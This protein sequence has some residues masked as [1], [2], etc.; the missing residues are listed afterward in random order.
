MGIADFYLYGGK[1]GGGGGSSLPSNWDVESN[2]LTIKGE[3]LNSLGWRCSNKDYYFEKGFSW[4][5]VD[6]EDDQ[7]FR[8]YD[9]IND[10]P[11]LIILFRFGGNVKSYCLGISTNA[12]GAQIK[13]R[14]NDNATRGSFEYLDHTWYY[15]RTNPGTDFGICDDLELIILSGVND[16]DVEAAKLAID[17]AGIS[18][19]A[20]ND[21]TQL[22]SP[23]KDYTIAA[24]GSASDFS[25]ATFKVNSSGDVYG[26]NFYSNGV[27]I[28][29][30]FTGATSSS[31]GAPGIVPAPSSADVN[32]FLK[33]DGSWAEAGTPSNWNINPTSL[34]MQD[35]GKEVNSLGWYCGNKENYYESTI[36]WHT[37]GN[38]HGSSPQGH[39]FYK[40]NTKPAL[41][42]AVHCVDDYWLHSLAVSTE[43]DATYFTQNDSGNSFEY[44]GH[45]WYYSG[46]NYS[47]P[48][49]IHT[50]SGINELPDDTFENLEAAA[51]YLIES[52]QVSF[53]S[54]KTLVMSDPSQEYIIQGGG[55][56]VDG[57]DATFKVNNNGGISGSSLTINGETISNDFVGATSLE[58]GKRGLVP[59]PGSFNK[60]MFLRGNG[61]WSTPGLDYS[62]NEQNTGIFWIDEYRTFRKTIQFNAGGQNSVG[63]IK[64]DIT[65]L[66]E[67]VDA[68]VN[69]YFHPTIT[70]G[71]GGTI[72]SDFRDISR[73]YR[74][75]EDGTPKWYYYAN[76]GGSDIWYYWQ[77]TVTIE[78]TKGPV[79]SEI[80][81][82]T[83]DAT[84]SVGFYNYVLSNWQSPRDVF[85][86]SGLTNRINQSLSA[87]GL[88]IWINNQDGSAGEPRIDGA[89]WVSC[90]LG[91][92]YVP[93]CVRFYPNVN[94]NWSG[95]STVYL[96]FSK[97]NVHWDTLREPFAPTGS[98]TGAIR[99]PVLTN[100][101]YSYVRVR[102]LGGTNAGGY[103]NIGCVA[104]IQVY[105]I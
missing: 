66:M 16:G 76:P 30:A 48:A 11:G 52:S 6:E 60:N 96:D 35:T 21:F 46:G 1:S 53:N 31:A 10:A 49:E 92:E 15:C 38:I 101:K 22:A 25:D 90:S 27:A 54:G 61:T 78:Y 95:T 20:S 83:S 33:G 89:D 80:I 19:E 75:V 17:Y 42:A 69:V 39:D 23:D 24:G 87:G 28:S 81:P 7:N 18:F 67:D 84:G 56:L 74:V 44:L 77:V 103:A 45:T 5:V 88:G 9:K 55:L 102:F 14:D 57:S 100:D 73:I 64:Y 32:K 79:E 70:G 12:G 51:K 2:S 43:E 59:A 98:S 97:D 29:S 99:L 62:T 91:G 3:G 105:G 68:L 37:T 65:S 85:K 36:H 93:Y 72:Y 47:L 40:T 13:D 34:V 86:T 104:G 63:T 8:T 94:N 71:S 50:V 41:I 4:T 82:I 58:D 26:G